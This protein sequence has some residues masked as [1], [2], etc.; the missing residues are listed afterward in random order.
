M[1]KI[2]RCGDICQRE[3]IVV[4]RHENAGQ[5]AKLMREKD[6][7]TVIVVE[8]E[9]GVRRPIGILTDRDLVMEVM[10]SDLDQACVSAE[11]L[12]E[13][14]LLTCDEGD[15]LPETLKRMRERGVR[16]IPVVDGSGYLAGVLSVSD[17]MEVL[18]GEI[19][20]VARLGSGQGSKVHCQH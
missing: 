13:P 16:R 7:G 5:V 8:G 9:V 10:A 19:M 18:A 12:M 17:V 14:D 15:D 6:V 2:M 20:E 4:S 1:V 3:T 11:D